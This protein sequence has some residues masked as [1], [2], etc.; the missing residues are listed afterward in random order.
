MATREEYAA[1]LRLQAHMVRRC[2][3]A[4]E[5]YRR[6]RVALD[7][8]IPTRPPETLTVRELR[9]IDEDEKIRLNAAWLALRTKETADWR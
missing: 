9:E 6:Q 7:E 8:Y 3:E 2:I 4:L 1:D 5:E